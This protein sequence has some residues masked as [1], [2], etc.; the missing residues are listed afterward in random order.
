[1]VK[2]TNVGRHASY[3]SINVIIFDLGK[4]ILDFDHF[5]ICRRLTDYCSFS[6]EHIYE[7]IFGSGLEAELD[8]GQIAPE[9]FFEKIKHGLKLD[10]DLASFRNFW[11]DIFSL[12]D[13]IA[14][15]IKKLKPHY[16]LMCLSNTNPWH[17]EFCLQRFS[18]L[19]D[20]DF[21][22]L[23]YQVGK[24][25]PDQEIYARALEEARVLPHQCL[26][27]DDINEY[28]IK[29]Q[30]LGITGIHFTSAAQLYKELCRMEIIK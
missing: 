8:Q 15:L 23:S 17:F 26:Y 11:N 30:E 4:V 14:A 6:P 24:R 12:N 5:L 13:D 20:F 22:I 9:K 19:R 16:L 18:I 1:M 7:I 3:K 29:A 27:I 28:I 25:K 10:L 2:D 21:F